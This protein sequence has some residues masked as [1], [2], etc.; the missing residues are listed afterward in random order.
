M[1]GASANSTISTDKL[2]TITKIY[3]LLNLLKFGNNSNIIARN[4]DVFFKETLSWCN[5]VENR[6]GKAV[7]S[8]EL[9]NHIVT[10]QDKGNYFVY[11]Y[12]RLILSAIGAFSLL[13]K[14]IAHIAN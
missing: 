8:E 10:L 4:S 6:L 3:H 11:Y 12:L 7:S 9:A 14:S 5:S 1:G 13:K 2:T